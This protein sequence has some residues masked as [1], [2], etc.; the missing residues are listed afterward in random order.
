MNPSS[1]FP[2]VAAS[3]AV[4]VALLT[5][6][7]NARADLTPPNAEQCQNKAAATA[8]VTEDGTDGTC[9]ESMCAG[10]AEVDAGD[11]GVTFVSSSYACGICTPNGETV[12]PDGGVTASTPNVDNGSGCNVGPTNA[13][14]A[15]GFAGLALG[16]ALV[17]RKRNATRRAR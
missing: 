7:A 17:L 12:L 11:G 5:G 14:S 9:Q 2:A 8:C 6:A 16:L 3:L 4:S 10:H 13:G 1:R 15:L